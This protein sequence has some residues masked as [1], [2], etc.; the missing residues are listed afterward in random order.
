MS[1]PLT[2]PEAIG[3]LQPG[4]PQQLPHFRD[5]AAAGVGQHRQ[6]LGALLQARRQGPGVTAVEADPAG[7]LPRTGQPGEGELQ[8]A[9]GGVEAQTLGAQSLDQEPANAEPEGVTT[10][11]HHRLLSPLE[12][13]D[14]GFGLVTGD[15][16]GAAPALQ[17]VMQATGGRHQ[18]RLAKQLLLVEGQR[19]RSSRVGANHLNHG[20]ILLLSDEPLRSP[21]T[22]A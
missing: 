11:Q 13:I 3:L 12:L 2:E 7:V 9:G 4:G 8:G 6:G 5:P 21:S 15:Q 14:Q 17:S 19:C 20:C 18:G 10:G 1:E 22:P 16:G